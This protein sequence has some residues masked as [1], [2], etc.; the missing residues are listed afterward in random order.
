MLY[1]DG[2]IT[3]RSEYNK[4]WKIPEHSFTESHRVP[5]NYFIYKGLRFV[6]DDVKD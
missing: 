5:Y 3:V 2:V 6:E 1:E 4:M